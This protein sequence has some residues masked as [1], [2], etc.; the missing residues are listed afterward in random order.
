MEFGKDQFFLQTTVNK[1]LFETA[2]IYATNK[3]SMGK[4]SMTTTTITITIASNYVIHSVLYVFYCHR[5]CLLL[6]LSLLLLFY[7]SVFSCVIFARK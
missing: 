3:N 6:S 5:S 4:R 1:M 7:Y 2:M